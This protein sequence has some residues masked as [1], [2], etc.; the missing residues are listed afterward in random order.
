MTFP[1]A[2]AFEAER[3]RAYRGLTELVARAKDAGRLRHDFSPE[4][5]VLLLMAN[6]GV[7]AATGD[8]APDAWRRFTAYMIQAFAAGHTDTLPPAPEP[9]A[10]YRAMLR[11]QH[12]GGR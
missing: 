8:D 4:D 6:A 11:L 1:T 9:A 5:L 10:L 12:G 2:R 7:V 3:A